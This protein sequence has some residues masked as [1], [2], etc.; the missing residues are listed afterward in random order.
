VKVLERWNGT[1]ERGGRVEVGRSGRGLRE[2]DD[3]IG[4][5]GKRGKGKGEE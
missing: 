4:K 1:Q 5:G 2:N 3:T